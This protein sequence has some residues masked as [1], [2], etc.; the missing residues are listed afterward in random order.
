MAGTVLCHAALDSWANESIP[1]G[2]EM[3]IKG[4][5]LDKHHLEQRG[6]EWRLSLIMSTVTSRPNLKSANP[7]LWERVLNLKALRDDIAHVRRPVAYASEY[8]GG[9]PQRT[10]YARLLNEGLDV[11]PGTVEAVMDHYGTAPRAVL[12]PKNTEEPQDRSQAKG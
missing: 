12:P 2:F 3:E 11:F 10:I 4:E 6:I 8:A 5:Q 9:D 1:D 7:D